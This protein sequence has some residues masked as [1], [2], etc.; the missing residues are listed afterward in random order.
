M[1]MSDRQGLQSTRKGSALAWMVSFGCG[2][3]LLTWLL[4]TRHRVVITTFW[5]TPFATLLAVGLVSGIALAIG[6]RNG[7]HGMRILKGLAISAFLLL[8]L[9][10]YFTETAW[11]W[12]LLPGLG[13]F[14]MGAFTGLGSLVLRSLQLAPRSVAVEITLG[15]VVGC[16]LVSTG[17]FLLGIV[18]LAA[19]AIIRI[20]WATA[21]LVGLIGALPLAGRARHAMHSNWA[22]LG[23][24]GRFV[25]GL[26]GLFGVVVLLGCL[27]A[28]MDY[29]ALEY[30]LA[31]PRHYLVWGAIRPTPLNFYAVFPQGAEMLF[32]GALAWVPKAFAGSILANALHAAALLSALP[33]CFYAA[34]RWAGGVE[35]GCAAVLLIVSTYFATWAAG[36][37]HVELFQLQAASAA[38]ACLALPANAWPKRGSAVIATGIAAGWG[39]CLKY[40]SIPCIALPLAVV[41]MV[42]GRRTPSEKP[43]VPQRLLPPILFGLTA[44][45]LWA[46]WGL[47]NLIRTGDPLFPLLVDW[48]P[49]A[50][51]DPI[52]QHQFTIIHTRPPIPVLQTGLEL[53]GQFAGGMR[54]VDPDAANRL[55]PLFWVLPWAALAAWRSR[56]IRVLAAWYVVVILLWLTTTFQVQRYVFFLAPAAAI[57]ATAGWDQIGAQVHKERVAVRVALAL[58]LLWLPFHLRYSWG[59]R[60]Y[61]NILGADVRGAERPQGVTLEDEVFAYLWHGPSGGNEFRFWDTLDHLTRAGLPIW[62]LG[63]AQ[64]YHVHPN[65]LTYATVFTRHPLEELVKS[66][67]SPDDLRQALIE[68][69]DPALAFHWE[70]LARLET[71][72]TFVD[73]LTGEEQ[74]GY[75]RFA[76]RDWEMLKQLL[77]HPDWYQR[78]FPSQAFPEVPAGPD[79]SQPGEQIRRWAMSYSD[80]LPAAPPR[81]PRIEILLPRT[82]VSAPLQEPSASE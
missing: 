40:T 7:L 35:A 56:A 33:G 68:A 27:L 8:A 64:T 32:M 43:T 26:T 25:V 79:W 22:Q 66:A 29:D 23:N 67:D 9:A 52:L 20:A 51:W 18:G 36:R 24:D 70:E 81:V 3:L 49:W 5:E 76:P 53:F 80:Q 4:Q 41:W 61:A 57:L 12:I 11:S 50:D 37:A 72:R 62:L 2:A 42:L 6:Y 21:V 55:G 63:E 47:R 58:A 15:A 39:A 28:P 73:P 78:V 65:G 10:A 19:P 48:L 75:W 46:P 38:L 82:R 45:A 16:W 14:M 34:R 17:T 30:H 31:L 59:A 54:E 77:N 69:G 60:M 71:S 13:L 1:D 44:L 74:S